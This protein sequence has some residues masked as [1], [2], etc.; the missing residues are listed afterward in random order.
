MN[1]SGQAARCLPA[2]PSRYR[3]LMRRLLVLIALSACSPGGKGSSKGV[4]AENHTFFPIGP[5]T[6]HELPAKVA[7]CESCHP[8]DA[9]SFKDFTCVSCHDA[10]GQP[11]AD[12]LHHGVAEYTFGAQACLACHPTGEH[13]PPFTHTGVARDGCAAC[14]ADGKAF[15]ALPKPG[16]T[17][18]DMGGS[19]CGSCHVTTTWLGG[20]LAPNDARDPLRDLTL[21]GL[22]P[23]W[24]GTTITTVMPVS[25][26]LPMRMNHASAQ[27]PAAANS[28]CR[29]C[30]A[31]APS[32]V[33]YP[34]IF[35]GSLIDLGL[36]EPTGCTDCH[37]DTEPVGFVGPLA[38]NPAR[39]PASAEMRHEAVGW[40]NDVRGTMR[41]VTQDCQLCHKAPSAGAQGAT[42]STSRADGGTT[43]YHAAITTAQQPQSCLDCHANTR[44]TLP[45]ALDGGIL[46][47]HQNPALLGDCR[48]CH[49]NAAAVSGASWVGGTFHAAVPAPST[50]LPC[51]AG[52]R[53]TSTASWRSTTYQ[54]SP[55]DYVTNARGV[56]HGAGQDCVT[57]HTR[58]QDW[59]G[60]N[61]VH[62]A[63]TLSASQCV[64]C[65]TTQRPDLL[66]GATAPMMA[67]LL[68]FD[69][70]RDGTGD[71]FGC[72]QATV[73]AG[74]YVN[75]FNPQTGM[76]PGGDWK[77]GVGYPGSFVSSTDLFIT[78]TET[79][80]NRSGP[81]NL[82][83][84][85]TSVQTTLYNGMLH[86]SAAVP[87][88][89]NAGATGTPDYTKCWH[90]HANDA[91]T[92]TA[93]AGGVYHQALDTY[94][95]TVGGAVMP[96]PQPTSRC[97]DCHAS[98]LPRNIVQKGTTNLQPMDHA[99]LFT[100]TVNIGGQMVSGVAQLDCSTCHADPG[101]TWGDGQ[102]H[103]KIGA[104][105]PRDCTGGCHYPLMAD[106]PKSDVTQAPTYKMAHRSGQL[107]FQACDRCHGTALSRA[108]MTPIAATLWRTG[109]FH[110]AAGTA[111]PAA[112]ND[113][114]APVSLPTTSTQGTVVYTL[115]Q[116]ATATN[117]AQW[118]NHASPVLAGRDCAVCHAA[119]AKSA[120]SAWS[121][122][123]KVHGPLAS[124]TTCREC[125]GL[126][127]GR[128]TVVGTNNNLPAGLIDTKT[129]TTAGANTGVPAGTRDQLSHADLNV[130][131]QDCR[132]C[133][134][135]QG[136][137]PQGSPAQGSEWAQALFHKSFSASNPLVTNGTTGRCSNCHLNVKPTAAFTA[138]N[139]APYTATSPQDCSSCHSW[140]GTNPA[141]PNWKGATGAHAASG[142]TA[143]SV[144]DC[145]TCHGQG[146]SANTR[147]MVPAANHYGGIANGNKC[148]S[149][150]IEFSGFKGT[151]ANLKY[152]HNNATA[153]AGGC[154]TCHFFTAGLYTTLTTTPPLT[155]PT[156]PGGKQFS[157]TQSVTGRENNDTG[158]PR[159]SFTSNHANTGLARCGSCHVYTAPTPTANVWT[160]RHDP[161]N[162]GINN[163]RT[164]PGC[165]MC[166]L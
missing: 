101:G 148:T 49:S 83:T 36:P 9:P 14:H 38:T 40:A 132:L 53:P 143:T 1:D 151:V 73:T 152:A 2:T 127:N 90:C 30:H 118:M 56:T 15:A 105:V 115:A 43:K 8:A 12:E 121:K 111:Q 166:H 32:G 122:A 33:Y 150:H 42:W 136:A 66:P 57:C 125:H 155:L 62:G 46:V 67:A 17:H 11:V 134:T 141:V 74:T 98:M 4:T 128:G 158:P 86:D 68:G 16:F 164:T 35:H 99:S 145:N 78:V 82:V 165:T 24:S 28:A 10:H 112:C 96:F 22:V 59:T 110:P 70:A 144:L 88:A 163:S 109:A 139:H 75:L 21:D 94:R 52:E 25:Q 131:S 3:G 138:F 87:A 13:T 85:T 50:C 156:T 19:D 76:L 18:P 108:A 54:R 27:Y 135:Q 23:S 162:P 6:K 39:V 95:A 123:A 154:Q 124:V 114:H 102:F 58:T 129:V 100:A 160:W 81:N 117:Q 34:G 44:P 92:V 91:G 51:H 45:V 103:S 26:K 104:A 55:F 84:S 106:A 65:H 147:L 48:T 107:T 71:C 142:P 31:D 119:D 159:G 47:D 146:G 113:C 37:A 60:G 69:H 79:R 64:S 97:N 149:C 41:L 77:N 140:P 126:T 137:A 157:A 7:T 29:N 72:H 116:G 61:F 161:N 93:Y 130:T 5:G 80:L 63:G 153:N 20:S 89:L 133:H 120:G